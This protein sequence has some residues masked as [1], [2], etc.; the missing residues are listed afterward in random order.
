MSVN[1]EKFPQIVATEIVLQRFAREI[2]T[3][4]SPSYLHCR[5]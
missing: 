1:F 2:F 3:I 5:V 4:L